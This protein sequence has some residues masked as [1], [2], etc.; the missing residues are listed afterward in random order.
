MGIISAQ[1]LSI[2]SSFT[3]ARRANSLCLQLAVGQVVVSRRGLN[4]GNLH[5][6]T[7][8]AR[9]RTNNGVAFRRRWRW[10]R[11]RRIKRSRDTLVSLWEWIGRWT[12]GSGEGRDRKKGR[13][14]NF[15][16]ARVE[17]GQ[18]AELIIFAQ[19]HRKLDNAPWR[20]PNKLTRQKRTISAS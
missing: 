15:R 10:R 14:G 5:S 1:P 11:R 16:Y 12:G 2:R 19:L 17:N 20:P 9:M 6:L 3:W 13:G 8:L 4:R 7:A 18:H